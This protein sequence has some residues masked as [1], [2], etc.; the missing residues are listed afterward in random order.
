M[1]DA[2]RILDADEVAKLLPKLQTRKALEEMF[3]SLSKGQAVQPSQT[4]TLLP[5]DRGDFITYMGAIDPQRVFGAK[6][7][8]YIVTEDK[9]LITAWTC[10]MSSATGRPLLL[11][12]SG[13]LTTERTAATTALAVEYLAR[14]NAQKLAIIGSG[15]VAMA[16]L[17][18]VLPLRDWQDIVVY[19]PSLAENADKKADWQYVDER[20]SFADSEKEAVVG[21]DVVML[22]TSSGT[23]VIDTADLENNALVTSISTNVANAHEV[24]PSFIPK[25]QVYCDY[26]ETTPSSAGEMKLAASEHG[27]STRSIVG[28]L[29]GLVS[30]SCPKPASDKPVFFRSIGLGL[31]DIA[32]AHALLQAAD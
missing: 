11:C 22:C 14:Q 15:A 6:L 17:R 25:A 5:D 10:L 30:G 4:I 18:H 24:P 9:P 19:S 2:I 8:P 27:W 26:S 1:A 21:A 20:V 31:E 3:L 12:D 29:P 32:I 13:Q 16:H 7:S 28:D 23:P